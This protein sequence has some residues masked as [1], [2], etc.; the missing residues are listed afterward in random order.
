MKKNV[1]KIAVFFLILLLAGLFVS[2]EKKQKNIAYTEEKS[3]VE[4]PEQEGWHEKLQ[5]TRESQKSAIIRYGHMQQYSKRNQ[6]Y[7]GNGVDVDFYGDTG[8][9]TTKVLADSATLEMGTSNLEAI[10]NVVVTMGDTTLFTQALK[11]LDSE[12]FIVCDVPFMMVTQHQDTLYGSRFTMNQ[13]N[14]QVRVY[15][16]SGVSHEALNI[17]GGAMAPEIAPTAK[18]DTT[19]RRSKRNLQ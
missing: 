17:R 1:L 8:V 4:V 2:C 11:W 14:H 18:R 7:F 16:A 9:I 6:I 5:L 10:G 19:R 15:R 12:K 3:P 13:L